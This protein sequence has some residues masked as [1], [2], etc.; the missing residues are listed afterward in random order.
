[1]KSLN[2]L[3]SW[4]NRVDAALKTYKETEENKSSLKISLNG[5]KRLIDQIIEYKEST[6]NKLIGKCFLIRP[7]NSSKFD[8]C[9]LKKIF[10]LMPNIFVSSGDHLSVLHAEKTIDY[11]NEHVTVK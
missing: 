10:E 4:N 11:I 1:M 7:T 2:S 9:G 6:T 3:P 8:D 5:V